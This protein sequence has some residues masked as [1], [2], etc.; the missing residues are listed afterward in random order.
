[1]N[2]SKIRQ[3]RL[4]KGMTLQ[5][6]ATQ[7]QTT[8]GYL[9]QLERDLVDPSLSTLRR[10]AEALDSPLFSL[11]DTQDNAARI[12]RSDGR[13]KVA[14]A[15]VNTLLEILTPRFYSSPGEVFV[16]TFTLQAHTWSNRQRVSH[17]VDECFYAQQG[18]LEVLVGEERYRLHQGDSIYIF[19]NTPH[20]I[21]NPG[22]EEVVG[23]SA[24]SSGFFSNMP[25]P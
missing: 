24:F 2:G 11:I 23:L 3:L 1:M 22:D 9:S 13:Q 25:R 4:A 8:A 15:G 16:M 12:I 5:Q 20:N 6:L 10:I 19:A 18:E 21:Y 17:S 7:T 14:F